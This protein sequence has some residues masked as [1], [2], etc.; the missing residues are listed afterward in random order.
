MLGPG[1][2][3]KNKIRVCHCPSGRRTHEKIITCHMIR[4]IMETCTKFNRNQ[5]EMKWAYQFFFFLKSV[6]LQ[7]YLP[8]EL[9][10]ELPSR[11]QL[12]PCNVGGKG[13]RTGEGKQAHLH[14]RLCTTASCP[15]DERTCS[16]DHLCVET[17]CW[18]CLRSETPAN[19]V[20]QVLCNTLSALQILAH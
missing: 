10:W 9:V 4:T 1:Q 13:G 12:H 19:L 2:A 17:L 3:R 6:C 11:G 15:W 5:E 16:D 14:C 18:G 20:C 7:V 8:L